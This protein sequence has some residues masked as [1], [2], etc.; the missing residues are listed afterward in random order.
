MTAVQ[1]LPTLHLVALTPDILIDAVQLPPPLHAD[2]ADRII[3]ATA[4]HLA[5]PI[6]T[7]DA[8]IIAYPHVQLAEPA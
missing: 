5:C 7:T 8:S 2:P 1:L 6:L 3:V 4:R